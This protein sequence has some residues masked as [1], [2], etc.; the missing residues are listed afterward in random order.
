MGE[1]FDA[2]IYT[3]CAPGEGLDGIAGMQFQSR[4]ADMSWDL[5]AVVRRHLLYEPPAPLISDHRPA[6]DFPPSLAH[7]WED[8]VLATA[9]GRYRGQEAIGNREGNHLTHAVVTRDPSTY[10]SI[11]PAQLAGA[12]FWE[13]EPRPTLELEPPPADWE[14][15]PIGP[16]EAADAVRSRPAGTTMLATLVTLL[17]DPRLAGRRRVVL[18][19]ED[20]GLALRWLT[21]ATLLLPQRRALTIGF[22]VFSM[23]PARSALKVVAAHPRWSTFTASVDHDLGYAVFDLDAGRCTEVAV[24]PEAAQW[25]TL[26]CAEEPGAVAE[27]IDLADASGLTGAE[28]RTLAVAATLG[29][30]PGRTALPAVLRWLRT[31]P[32]AVRETYGSLVVAAVAP[33]ADAGTLRDL[34]TIARENNFRQQ[35]SIRAALLQSDLAQAVADPERVLRATTSP[36]KP[37]VGPVPHAA[38]MILAALREQRGRQFGAVLTVAARWNV[39]V[40]LDEI[41][42]ATAAFIANWI[43]DPDAP[44]DVTGWRT[45]PSLRQRLEEELRRRVGDEAKSAVQAA[46]WCRQ[47]RPEPF[48]ADVTDVFDRSLL[49]AAMRYSD[50]RQRQQLVTLNLT[51]AVSPVAGGASAA[52]IDTVVSAL[53]HI[54]RPTLDELRILAGAVPA[55]TPVDPGLLTEVTER[56]AQGDPVP[57]PE[58]ALCGTFLAKHLVP[59]A[60]AAGESWDAVRRLVAANDELTALLRRH[61]DDHHPPPDRLQRL[62]RAL[63][64]AHADVL[65]Q[66]LAAV[67]DLRVLERLVQVMPEP[68][69][70]G[71]IVRQNHQGA[72]WS[73]ARAAVAYYLLVCFRPAT[74]SHMLADQHLKAPVATWIGSRSR[75][76]ID[77]VAAH[78]SRVS[79]QMVEFWQQTVKTLSRPKLLPWRTYW[80]KT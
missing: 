53:W 38:E 49:S 57:L 2:A 27:A 7:V 54:A 21:A 80:K 42:D 23:E 39:P 78:L 71:L 3:N 77:A 30:P 70:A 31:G 63:L 17:A 4:T 68:V 25:A 58:L 50:H 36:V 44:Y 14:P 8:D 24:D 61:F 37:A 19:T 33:H 26:F 22:K 46:I 65:A 11:R 9:S 67:D 56:V 66:R 29:R 20:A 41:G 6:A 15:G 40:R 74:P 12:T 34:E 32:E 13:R 75:D 55:R 18:C 1:T 51:A 10:G 16:G 73:P 47:L 76:D 79:P 69:L 59:A 52:R 43:D 62:P 64:K 5:L 35:T 48:T 72:V 45:E 28:A 60:P